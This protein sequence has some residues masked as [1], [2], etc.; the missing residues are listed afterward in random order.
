M[1]SNYA[2]AK[3]KEMKLLFALAW[4]LLAFLPVRAKESVDS[5]SAAL[6]LHPVRDHWRVDLLNQLG[7]EYWI[8]NPA[9]SELL[10]KEAL[11]LADSLGYRKGS[12]FAK[13]VI[14]VSYWTRGQYSDALRYLSGGLL[15]YQQLQDHQGMGCVHNNIG[16]VYQDQQN[17]HAALGHFD[18]ALQKSMA[19]GDT[20]QQLRVL[21]NI[22]DTY[23]RMGDLDKAEKIFNQT[24]HKNKALGHTYDIGESYSSLGELALARK[25]MNLALE[26][27][28]QSVQIRTGL[29]D[30]EGLA[31]CYYLMGK[32][33]L[34]QGKYGPAEKHLFRSREAALAVNSLK[35]LTAVYETLKNLEVARGNHPA[36]VA[37]FEA[38]TASKDSLFNQEK[39]L[40]MARLQVQSETLQKD[41]QLRLQQKELQLLRHE[42]RLHTYLR[43]GLLLGLAAIAAILYLVVSRQRLKIRQKEALLHMSRQALHA[44]EALARAERENARLQE[45]ELMQELEQKNKK[46]TSYSINFIQKNELIEE[47][48]C[49]I[50]QLKKCPGKPTTS[51][52]SGLHRLVE[53]NGQIDRDWEDFK[54]HFEE[55]HKDFYKVLKAHHPELTPHE[56]KLCTLLKLNMNLK[57]ASNI[58][59]I[60]PE[61]VKK[62]RYRLR[63]KFNL[64]AGENLI[65]HIIT[66]E[67]RSASR[68]VA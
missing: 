56:L 65:D 4:V 68:Q 47:L 23:F 51:Q 12:A 27:L 43:N 61:S 48:K 26:H 10:G 35:W 29:E 24:L 64:S 33:Y 55:V 5:L 13:R 15:A 3:R 45:L 39:S 19:S 60:S 57:E 66:L 38:F 34:G 54:L 16:L 8:I 7:Y 40:Q 42:A 62:A 36:A 2:T 63:K 52:L 58:M 9:R 28:R 49:G 11:I 25:D 32:A 21:G 30:R 50:N 17:Y 37:Y 20:R 46:L 31:K 1:Q 44:Q 6:M 41:Q 53:Q 22:G 59:G 14:G 18:K 67:S